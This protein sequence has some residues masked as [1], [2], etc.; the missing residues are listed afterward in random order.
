ME[1]DENDTSS[2]ITNYYAQYSRDEL[3]RKF[4]HF[5]DR[6]MKAPNEV[7]EEASFVSEKEVEGMGKKYG[8]SH[9]YYIRA[10]GHKER[11]CFPGKDEIGVYVEFLETGLRFPLIPEVE[12]VYSSY[13]YAL[14]QFMP[15]S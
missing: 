8:F 6:P 11:I 14:A 9:P 4:D 5:I 10:P 1:D 15:T 2:A 7:L 12:E 3:M 13:G